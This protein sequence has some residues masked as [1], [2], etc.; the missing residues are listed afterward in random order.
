MRGAIFC[1]G[2]PKVG[3]AKR[4]NGSVDPLGTRRQNEGTSTLIIPLSSPLS[5]LSSSFSC[6]KRRVQIEVCNAPETRWMSPSAS[7]HPSTAP[8]SQKEPLQVKKKERKKKERRCRQ[9]M[10]M[11]R[12][13]TQLPRS[14][15]PAAHGKHKRGLWCG[16]GSGESPPSALS[17]VFA[18]EEGAPVFRCLHIIGLRGRVALK[19][20]LRGRSNPSRTHD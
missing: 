5:Y 3:L 11:V 1:G 2:D 6:H 8:S 13:W 4:K 12:Q 18:W 19:S 20:S 14:F 16:R 9:G 17:R 7:S 10:S 15:D